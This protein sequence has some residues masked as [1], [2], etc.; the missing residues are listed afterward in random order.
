MSPGTE[1]PLAEYRKRRDFERT[2]EP[3]GDGGREPGPDRGRFVVQEHHARSLHWDLRLERDGAL[4]SWAVPKGLP[5][6]PK[7]DRLAVRT[8][9]HPIEY[10]DFE[11]EIPPGE[12]GSGQMKIWDRGTFDTEKWRPDEVIVVLNGARLS[13]RYVLFRTSGRNWMVHRMDPPDDPGREPMP[14]FVAPMLASPAPTPPPDEGWG[15]EIKW[16]GIRA[17]VNVDGGRAQLLSRNGRDVTATYPELR[18]LGPALGSLPAVLD[19]EIVAFDDGKP[20]F[21]RLQR[22]MNLDGRKVG[23]RVVRE[24]PVALVLFDLLW[25]D[26]HSLLGLPYTERR[27]L[28]EHLGLDGPAWRTPGSYTESGPLL[29]AT[30]EQGL[31][32]IVAKRLDSVYEPGTRSRSW[33]K[34]KHFRTGDLVVAGWVEG[35]ETRAGNLGA[36]VLATYDDDGTLRHRGRVGTGFCDADRSLLQRLLA[37]VERATSPLAGSPESDAHWVDPVYVASVRFAELTNSGVLRSASFRGLRPD[38]EPES[39]TSARLDAEA[40]SG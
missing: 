28:L 7:E 6:H 32:G 22:R 34:V 39:A 17:I 4:A 21:E 16:D 37:D 35:S 1:E 29:E 31:E 3:A 30:R 15:F 36:L 14:A 19:G 12:Y 5:L 10:L 26:G 13:G 8:E 9:D 11:G 33:V 24:A 40:R 25:L 20:S 18:G 23:A 27:H 2:P 38:V